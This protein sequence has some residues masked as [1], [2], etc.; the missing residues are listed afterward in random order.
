MSLSGAPSAGKNFYTVWT[1]SE[2]IA[3]RGGINITTPPV[4]SSGGRYD[5][6]SD[7]WAPISLPTGL[8]SVADA[9]AIWTGT[10]MLV[11]SGDLDFG[12]IISYGARFNPATNTWRGLSGVGGPTPRT[13]VSSVWTGTRMIVWGG[14]WGSLNYD[15]GGIYDPV[16][17]A[18]TATSTVNAPI[19]RTRHAAVWTGDSMIIWGGVNGG[20]LISGGR[21]S[22]GQ[23]SDDDHDGLSEC[24]GDCNDSD[25]AV[26]PGAPQVCE[27]HKN[28]DCLASSWP[29]L[30]GTNEADDD[31]D[32]V[33]ECQDDCDDSNPS[34]HPGA[35]ELCD[36]LDNDCNG[37]VPADEADTDGDGF[38]GCENDCND[39]DASVNPLGVELPGN[40]LDENCDGVMS[41]S[42]AAFYRNHGEFIRC[43]A[44][45]C[46]TLMAGSFVSEGQC[47][48]LVSQA[49][50]SNVGRKSRNRP[51]TPPVEP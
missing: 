4:L 31:G 47:D 37:V 51:R 45:E 38:R 35:A 8:S 43:V 34:I 12:P 23:S 16:S 33:T 27:D 1:G 10:E 18:W 11:W 39:A 42:P 13:L 21:Y 49:A 46:G 29:S 50:R 20:N 36:S 32:T 9:T 6:L 48:A 40:L 14:A 22:Y 5:P 24:A 19:A 28:N 7:S 17:E 41:C 44:H 2:M 25:L 30:A 26:Y 3:W 15:T